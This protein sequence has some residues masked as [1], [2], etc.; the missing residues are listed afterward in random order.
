MR[1]RKEQVV[2]VVILLMGIAAITVVTYLNQLHDGYGSQRYFGL[3]EASLNPSAQ[4]YGEHSSQ[5]SRR[6]FNRESGTVDTVSDGIGGGGSAPEGRVHMPSNQPIVSGTSGWGGSEDPEDGE[7][8]PAEANEPVTL[9]QVLGRL[10]SDSAGRNARTREGPREDAQHSSM[11]VGRTPRPGTALNGQQRPSWGPSK[12]AQKR[13][14][15]SLPRGQHAMTGKASSKVPKGTSKGAFLNGSQ[16][17]HDGSVMAAKNASAVSDD[18]YRIREGHGTSERFGLPTERQQSDGLRERKLPRTQTLRS[19]SDGLLGM[20]DMKRT[21]VEAAGAKQTRMVRRFEGL[22]RS[23]VPRTG[24]VFMSSRHPVLQGVMDGHREPIYRARFAPS[25]DSIISASE[26]GVV[27]LWNARNGAM[28]RSLDTGASP[29]LAFDT[30]PNW[31]R[32]AVLGCNGSSCSL[33]ALDMNTGRSDAGTRFGRAYVGTAAFSPDGKYV[34]AG[35]DDGRLRLLSIRTSV[36]RVWQAHKEAIWSIAF[37]RYGR[38]LATGSM[39]HSVKIW[40]AQ[41]GELLRT[42]KEHDGAI[43][44]IAFAPNGIYLA[45]A[46]SDAIIRV[47]RASTGQQLARL[48]GHMG[49]V[50]SLDFDPTSQRLASCGEHSIRIW[51]VRSREELVTIGWDFAITTLAFSPDGTTLLAGDVVGLLT[52]WDAQV[53]IGLNEAAQVLG[54]DDR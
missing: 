2:F 4:D 32:L 28:E 45:T 35:T 39:D 31:Q 5:H 19:R 7:R 33:E 26:S 53:G 54:K 36:E 42:L 50:R 14:F 25:G 51:D 6:F 21:W 52:L 49:T 10:R 30:A 16:K 12:R 43:H 15:R 29:L 3:S 38:Y 41:T 47:Y 18:S 27:Q 37:D 11:A 20:R 46:G 34:A 40:N 48:S 44:S 13:P 1:N 23:E 9:S 24:P 8:S 17:S 22:R